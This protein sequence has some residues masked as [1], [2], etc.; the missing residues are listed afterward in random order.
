LNPLEKLIREL[1]AERG[2]LS[3]SDYMELALY[4]PDLGYYSRP[5]PQTGFGGHFVTSAELGPEF[6]ALWATALEDLW[7]A[8][9]SPSSF[10]VVEVGPGEGGLAAGILRAATGDFAEALRLHLVERSSIRAQRQKAA[11]PDERVT[12]HDSVEGVPGETACVIANEVLDNLPVHVVE[13]S[14]GLLF[15][16]F[17]DA[18]PDGLEEKLLPLKDAALLERAGELDVSEGGR[19]EIALASEVF[20]TT[21]AGLVARGA[22]FFIDYG[23]SPEERPSRPRGTLVSYSPGGSDDLVLARPGER[24]I[25]AHADWGV[26]AASLASSGLQVV[27]PVR[28]RDVL[29]AL[30]AGALH[31]KLKEDHVSALS[32]GRGS[33]AV[34]ALARR[35]VL[36]TLTDPG[37]LGGLQVLAGFKGVGIPRWLDEAAERHSY[38]ENS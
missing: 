6:G 35:Q 38:N 20:T 12:W 33:D 4:H 23:L 3:F 28:Q 22:V 14:D 7:S 32:S 37:G 11:L 18:G 21:C 36:G 24:D 34:K 10:D 29:R 26:V 17:V 30:G 8:C 15:E 5:E 1:I 9:D 27:G 19:S 25:T 2:P 16:V 31:E 13:R